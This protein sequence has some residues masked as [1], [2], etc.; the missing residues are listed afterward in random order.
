ML[1][2]TKR[3]SKKLKW[4]IAG[5]GKFTETAILPTFNLIPRAKIN[6]IFSNDAKRAKTLSEKFLIPKAFDNFDEFLKSDIDVV[7]IASANAHHYEQV[8]KAAKAKKHILCE[9]PLSITTAQAEEM[10]RVCKENGVHFAVDFVYRFHPL[11][12]K[13]KAIIESSLLGKI[14]YI[15]AEFNVNLLP[16]DN[17][18]YSKEAAGGG[19]VRDLGT[20]LLDLMRFLCGEIVELNGVNESLFYQSE[21]EDFAAGIVKFERGGFGHFQV[22]YCVPKSFNRME[23]IG[24]KGAIS[25]D[26]LISAR[27]GSAKLSI[28]LEG[29]GKKVFRKRANKLYRLL[30]SVTKSILKNEEPLVTGEDG[31]VNM[32]LMEEF[33]NRCSNGKS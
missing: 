28:L 13:A 9:K 33:E 2:I 8:L 1:G 19:A 12:E 15:N 27:Y 32:R 29:E 26:G 3:I 22:A 18:R 23:I 20:H 21:V 4:G 5:C 16:R 25:L 24:T 10:V 14:L 31:L 7:Y 11:V 30:K 17:F 6:A